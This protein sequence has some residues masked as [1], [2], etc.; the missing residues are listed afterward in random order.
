MPD[1]KVTVRIRVTE[2]QFALL[3]ACVK[4]ALDRAILI[5]SKTARDLYALLVAVGG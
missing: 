3:I 4:I 5:R 2:L 1:K